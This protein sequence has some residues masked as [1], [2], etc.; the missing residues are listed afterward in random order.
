MTHINIP[1]NRRLFLVGASAVSLLPSSALAQETA[2]GI[3][4]SYSFQGHPFGATVTVLGESLLLTLRSLK[5]SSFRIASVFTPT[6]QSDARTALVKNG[7]ET[8]ATVMI[9]SSGKL[10]LE[11]RDLK[12]DD[13]APHPTGPG[14]PPQTNGLFGWIGSIFKGIGNLVTSIGGLIGAGV[15]WLFGWKINWKNDWGSVQ[16]FSDGTVWID[17]FGGSGNGFMAPPPGTGGRPGIWY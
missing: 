12:L 6:K 15:A 10:T 11:G 14:Q 2:Q 4:F 7:K 1:M 5:D 3:R 8:F 17:V 9:D 13:V 16:V